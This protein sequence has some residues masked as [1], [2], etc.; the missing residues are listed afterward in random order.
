MRCLVGRVAL[1]HVYSSSV[2]GFPHL[3]VI[4]PL[5]HIHLSL[6]LRYDI[7]DEEHFSISMVFKFGACRMSQVFIRN[8]FRMYSLAGNITYFSN[9]L[10][11]P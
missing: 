10:H 3:V 7:P 9:T 6:L 11:I 8:H 4:L 5:L 1:E 2:F